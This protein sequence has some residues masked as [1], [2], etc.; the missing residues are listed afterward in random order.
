PAVGIE[1]ATSVEQI[2]RARCAAAVGIDRATRFTTR[3]AAAIRVDCA[4]AFKPE[5]REKTAQIA[6]EVFRGRTSRRQMVLSRRP[7]WSGPGPRSSEG[8]PEEDQDGCSAKDSH[9]QFLSGKQ[10][11]S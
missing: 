1:R 5:T 3:C 7:G 2:L 8:E 4:A 6:E 10:L 9:D 11:A